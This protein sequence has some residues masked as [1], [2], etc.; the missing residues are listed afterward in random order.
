MR[1]F[2]WSFLLATPAALSLIVAAYSTTAARAADTPAVSPAIQAAIDSPDRP[3]ADKKRDE[4]RRPAIVLQFFGIRPG[5]TLIEYYATGGNTAELLARVVGPKGKVYMQNPP[6]FYQR[7]SPSGVPTTKLVEDRLANNRLPNVVRLDRP[8]D[9][10]GLPPHSVDGAVM[11]LVFHDMFY[12]TDDHVEAVLKN[13]YATLKPGGFVGVVDHSA[14]AG[15]GK[16]YALKA[17]GQHR[18]DEDYAKKMFREA[19]FVLAKESNAL[20]NPDDDRQKP[21]FAPEMRGKL[22]D[23]FMLLF[24]K[25]K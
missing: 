7:V 13:L 3:E 17:D 14:P 19:G 8:F 15:T 16:E 23:R 1:A 21:F 24:R 11:N 6:A 4:G 25:P 9:D 18:I 12:A 10:L 20:R 5:Q 22:T 2:K